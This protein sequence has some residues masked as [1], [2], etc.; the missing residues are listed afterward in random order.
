MSGCITCECQVS[1]D[2]SFCSDE[3]RETYYREASAEQ[4]HDEDAEEDPDEQ[5]DRWVDEDCNDAWAGGFAEN[6]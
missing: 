1:G 3:C 6:H 2:D 4:Q 5:W